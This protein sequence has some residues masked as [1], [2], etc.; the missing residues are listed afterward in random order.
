MSACSAC[1]RVGQGDRQGHAGSRCGRLLCYLYGSGRA[2]EH[3]DP[4]L[5]AGFGDPDELK[6]ERRANGSHDLRRLSG[7]L[8]QPMAAMYG[9]DYEKPV[10]HC[11]FCGLRLG[12][13]GIRRCTERRTPATA[14][15]A[16]RTASSRDALTL[17]I[18]CGSSPGDLL[19]LA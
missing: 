2:N 10:R 1:S 8:A 4:H 18:G 16:H 11:S 13:S 14:P 17:A 5:V 19:P 3:T 9:S 12:C 7:L 15:H 6:P